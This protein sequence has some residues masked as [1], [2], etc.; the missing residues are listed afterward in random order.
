M[1]ASIVCVFST[2]QIMFEIREEE[3]RRYKSINY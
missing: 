3:K 2:V 1:I